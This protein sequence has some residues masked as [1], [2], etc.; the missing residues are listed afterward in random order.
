ME[1]GE[2]LK[3]NDLSLVNAS[4]R[5][6]GKSYRDRLIAGE[7][8]TNPSKEIDELLKDNNGFL[9]FQEDVSKFLMQICGLSGSEA[10][11]VR[12]AIASKHLDELEKVLPKILRGYCD[13]SDKPKEIAEEEA[14]QFVQI[15]IDSASYMFGYNHSTGYSMIGYNC[16]YL[17]YYYPL[18]FTTA[19][20]NNADNEADAVAGTQLAQTL[21]IQILPPKFRYSKA[22]YMCDKHTNTI[23]KGISSIKYLNAQVADELYDLRDNQY[24]SFVD[25]L[26]DITTKTSINSRQLDILIKLDYF[27]EFG[28]S[29]KLLKCVEYFNLFNNKKQIKKDKVKELGIDEDII[30]KYSDETEKQ[31]NKLD[32][33]E[34]IKEFYNTIEN[35]S[36]SL[37]DRI[38]AELEFLGYISFK[39]PRAK[40]NYYVVIEYKTYKDKTKPYITLYQ[41]KT[42]NIIKTN[43]KK[44]KTFVENPFKLYSV[45][46]VLDFKEEYKKKLIDG[47][48]TNTDEKKLV[49][50]QWQ[51]M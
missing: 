21:N 31:Y 19:Y 20:L 9:V 46:K 17:R 3:I 7:F 51:V 30:K 48:W 45:L 42:G 24:D 8:N 39:E 47:K 40:E 27:S 34:I 10:D 28:K 44:G 23:Y 14:K 32:S 2:D 49:L 5:P 6:S 11:N 37:Q 43:V 12:R 4:L 50:N 33:V 18:E 16:A 15:L 26:I 25:L 35:K 41:L 13:Y 1:A 38:E 29:R 36:I 22:E